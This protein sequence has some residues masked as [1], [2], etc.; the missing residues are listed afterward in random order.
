MQTQYRGV[1]VHIQ[2]ADQLPTAEGWR[3]VAIDHEGSAEDPLS[4]Q[5]LATVEPITPPEDPGGGKAP[6]HVWPEARMAALVVPAWEGGLRGEFVQLE[7]AWTTALSLLAQAG[8]DQAWFAPLGTCDTAFPT[9]RAAYVAINAIARVLEAGESGFRT[10]VIVA[11]NDDEK[12]HWEAATTEVLR[13]M[14]GT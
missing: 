1:D 7:R 11:P 9:D 8:A 5:A 3:V 13:T 2:V 4:V 10:L 12:A 14:T 6:S